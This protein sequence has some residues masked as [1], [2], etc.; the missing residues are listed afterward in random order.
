M[1]SVIYQ[2]ATQSRHEEPPI[3]SPAVGTALAAAHGWADVA[4]EEREKCPTG[5]AASVELKRRRQT[6][7][8]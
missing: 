2:I 6:S 5:V 1:N 3:D 8:Q 4:R 7:A